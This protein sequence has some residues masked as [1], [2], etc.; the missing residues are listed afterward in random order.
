MTS[1][2][3]EGKNPYETSSEGLKKP[4]SSDM[5]VDTAIAEMLTLRWPDYVD[6]ETYM[7]IV[8]KRYESPG[9]DTDA[10]S[11]SESTAES[12]TGE[13]P[14]AEI[15]ATMCV[16]LA[17]IL[18]D[19]G[20]LEQCNPLVAQ[21]IKNSISDAVQALLDAHR[22]SHETAYPNGYND[23]VFSLQA[24][25]HALAGIAVTL[26]ALDYQQGF[27]YL[28]QTYRGRVD[29]QRMG[30]G[31]ISNTYPIRYLE[32]MEWPDDGWIDPE[33]EEIPTYLDIAAIPGKRVSFEV[34][35]IPETLAK[36]FTSEST[37]DGRVRSSSSFSMRID[38]DEKSPNGFSFDVGR[39]NRDGAAFSRDGD[40]AGNSLQAVHETGSHFTDHFGGI[41][42]VD[43]EEFIANLAKFLEADAEMKRLEDTLHESDSFNTS[44]WDIR[45]KNLLAAQALRRKSAEGLGSLDNRD[46]VFSGFDKPA[47]TQ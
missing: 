18:C 30:N 10:A 33:N 15:S 6:E 45:H 21:A 3:L 23:P 7:D 19:N 9:N 11:H 20:P 46:S 29:S 39:D 43:I 24:M 28:T 32:A 22:T 1:S 16:E 40:P 31:S 2:L 41:T 35:F 27:E 26:G 8:K 44:S 38:Y 13:I 25:E 36:R 34:R 42:P 37:K 12:E 4:E 17:G 47:N 14:M 5:T